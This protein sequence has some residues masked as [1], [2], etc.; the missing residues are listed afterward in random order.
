MSQL[1]ISSNSIFLLEY[2]VGQVWS[3]FPK[4]EQKLKMDNLIFPVNLQLIF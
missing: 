3:C 2:E 1:E 4:S